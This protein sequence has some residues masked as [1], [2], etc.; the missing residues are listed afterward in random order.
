MV[1]TYRTYQREMKMIKDYIERHCPNLKTHID[2]MILNHE[3]YGNM[4]ASR[5]L[6]KVA[7]SAM[8]LGHPQIHPSDDLYQSLDSIEKFLEKKHAR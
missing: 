1:V 4:E 2:Q 7:E 5:F 8:A 6:W 3:V